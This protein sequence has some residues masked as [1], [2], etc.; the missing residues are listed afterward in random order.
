MPSLPV[1]ALMIILP[2]LLIGATLLVRRVCG[3][4]P[5]DGRRKT[6]PVLTLRRISV[7]PEWVRQVIIKLKAQGPELGCRHIAMSFNRR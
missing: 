1:L 6:L 2:L 7:K 5:R 4:I 3:N